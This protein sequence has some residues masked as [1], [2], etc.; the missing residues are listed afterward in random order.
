[1][2]SDCE[3]QQRELIDEF[4]SVARDAGVECWLRG[5]WVHAGSCRHSLRADVSV[6][7]AG[8]KG[9]LAFE[10]PNEPGARV[11]RR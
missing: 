4:V 7:G 3:R 8:G 1:M 9:V 11:A 2:A 6:T 10:A 5:R